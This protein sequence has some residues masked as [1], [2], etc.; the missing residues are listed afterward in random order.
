MAVET[1]TVALLADRVPGRGHEVGQR[2]PG[3]CASLDREMLA[4]VDRG[5]HGPGHRDL[6]RPLGPADPGHRG[7]EQPVNAVGW[8][9]RNGGGGHGSKRYRALGVRTSSSAFSR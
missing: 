6:A 8:L 7:R 1:T 2:L 4:G 5:L 3:S 9:L